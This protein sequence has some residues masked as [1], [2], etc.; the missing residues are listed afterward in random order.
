[1]CSHN[2]A[3]T[4][5]GPGIADLPWVAVTPINLAYSGV[6]VATAAVP[7]V[8]MCQP[9]RNAR[10]IATD[11]I[12]ERKPSERIM[13]CPLAN[14]IASYAPPC[15]AS[16]R[17]PDFKAGEIFLRLRRVEGFAHHHEALGRR[18]RRRQPGF[19]HQL[20]GVGGEVDLLSDALVVDVALDLTPALHLRHDPHRE[21][22]PGERIEI[23]AVRLGDDVAETVRKCAGEN[24]LQHDR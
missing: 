7:R 24:L 19:L 15:A 4:S 2:F 8:A 17:L 3:P 5:S 9:P 18:G 11:T 20:C 12:A 1:M 14:V 6:M 23:D 10:K 16:R 13:R 22:L 21:G